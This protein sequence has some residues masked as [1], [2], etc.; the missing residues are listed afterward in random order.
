MDKYPL[1][2]LE[3]RSCCVFY[4]RYVTPEESRLRVPSQQNRIKTINSRE[5]LP[6]IRVM[7]TG[8]KI[9]TPLIHY[10]SLNG[11]DFPN[12]GH[13]AAQSTQRAA[14][15]G[16]ADIGWPEHSICNSYLCMS[17]THSVQV[18]REA[19]VPLE[20]GTPDGGAVLAARGLTLP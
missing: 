13:D 15:G 3:S 20:G 2:D 9:T 1:E 14:P 19:G 4:F 8:R 7:N 11:S 17:E 12:K 10:H 5:C 6:V 18:C 16:G